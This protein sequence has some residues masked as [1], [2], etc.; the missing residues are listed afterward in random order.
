MC[1]SHL[2]LSLF[3]SQHVGQS[4][5]DSQLTVA[6]GPFP[7]QALSPGEYGASY[8]FGRTAAF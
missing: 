1:L 6:L 3:P 4:T 2:H 8:S 5:V 7:P